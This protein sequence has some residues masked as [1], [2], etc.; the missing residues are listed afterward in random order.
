MPTLNSTCCV[1]SLSLSLAYIRSLKRTHLDDVGSFLLFYRTVW[2]ASS[3]TRTSRSCDACTR[4]LS[5]RGL[6]IL[7]H[8]DWPNPLNYSNISLSLFLFLSV[9]LTYDWPT[10]IFLALSFSLALSLFLSFSQTDL[11]CWPTVTPTV[12]SLS[13]SLSLSLSQTDLIYWPTVIGLSTTLDRT[14]H[15]T[16]Q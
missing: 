13:L 7:L 11:F 15:A 16:Q 12:I 14:K 6:V 8:A 2:P 3:M 9:R 5:D 4:T 10:T 1:T